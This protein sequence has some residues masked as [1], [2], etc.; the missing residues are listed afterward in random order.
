MQLT[1]P[2]HLPID[3]Q[4]DSFILGNNSQLVERLR[5]FCGQLSNS[6]FDT[7]KSQHIFIHSGKGQGKSHLLYALCHYAETLNVQ[8]FYLNLEQVKDMPVSLILGLEHTPL[9]CIDDVQAIKSNR[10]WQIALFDLLNQRIEKQTG[11]TVFTS[12]IPPVNPEFQTESHW[13][14][15]LV[16]RF[17][18]GETY[19]IQPLDHEEQVELLNQRA[20]LKGLKFSDQAMTFILNHCERNTES[21]VQI[22]ERLDKR[23]MIEKKPLS[24]NM[25]KREL[26]L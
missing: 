5:T 25:V 10:E 3:Q 12:E 19:S 6:E 9:L 13:L 8:S 18:W 26:G 7:Q 11:L 24:V 20:D 21:L 22:I 23:S 2:V 14:P 17:S 1:L 16:S 15:D 4:F